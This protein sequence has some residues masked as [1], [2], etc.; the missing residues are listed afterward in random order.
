MSKAPFCIEPTKKQ[1]RM[2]CFVAKKKRYC[3][4]TLKGNNL[5]WF[6]VN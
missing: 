1:E 6:K 3:V 4:I 5:K 2:F